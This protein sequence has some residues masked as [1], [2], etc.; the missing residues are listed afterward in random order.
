MANTSS[1]SASLLNLSIDR[2]QIEM[3]PS[4]SLSKVVF[5][6]F[7]SSTI[8]GSVTPFGDDGEYASSCFLGEP[9]LGDSLGA[10]DDINLAKSS[11]SCGIAKKDFTS[12]S[13]CSNVGVKMPLNTSRRV[14]KSPLSLSSLL[15]LEPKKCRL[16][17]SNRVDRHLSLTT[18][19]KSPTPCDNP[20]RMGHHSSNSWDRPI[21]FFLPLVGSSVADMYDLDLLL[22]S[23]RGLASSASQSNMSIK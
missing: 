16:M 18:I 20:N 6:Q 15:F 13:A 11:G 9:F 10:D 14:C 22:R 8:A 3:Q 21:L 4:K 19:L 12:I 23:G 1:T 7:S 17:I 5:N 2:M